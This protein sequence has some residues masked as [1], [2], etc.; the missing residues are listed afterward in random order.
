MV[1]VFDPSRRHPVATA[2][3]RSRRNTW[4][5]LS[6][7]L[8]LAMVAYA[9]SAWRSGT[10]QRNTEPAAE[11][12]VAG[13]TRQPPAPSAA[14]TPPHDQ[15]GGEVSDPPDEDRAEDVPEEPE[16][17]FAYRVISC[18]RNQY[19][20]ALAGVEIQVEPVLNLGDTPPFTVIT[21]PGGCAG[22]WILKG[23]YDFSATFGELTV[24]KRYRV[25]DADLQFVDLIFGGAEVA[26]GVI[27]NEAGRPVADAWVRLLDTSMKTDAGVRLLDMSMKTD[28]S[29]RYSLSS[30]NRP[31]QFTVEHPD[32]CTLSLYA[33]AASEI[34]EVIV[35]RSRPRLVIH[36]S[37]RDGAPL[38]TGATVTLET[39][40]RP[41]GELSGGFG[42]LGSWQQ[43][44][45]PAGVVHFGSVDVGDHVLHAE[46]GSEYVPT[47]IPF[48]M[49]CQDRV[50][51]V[52][53]MRAAPP[54]ALR[55]L[56]P[57]G[58][59]VQDAQI[60]TTAPDLAQ[61]EL[62]L[63]GVTDRLGVTTLADRIGGRIDRITLVALAPYLPP[64][65]W[66]IPLNLGDLTLR[67]PEPAHLHV[68]L[69]EEDRVEEG[70][71]EKNPW[72]AER[73]A[74]VVRAPDHAILDELLRPPVPIAKGQVELLLPGGAFRIVIVA[75]DI[76][77]A[78]TEVTLVAGEQRRLVIEPG[79]RV[80]VV[81]RVRENGEDAGGG[82]VT[83]TQGYRTAS[84]TVSP[85]GTFALSVYGA[86]PYHVRYQR[87]CC[88][89]EAALEPP[90]EAVAGETPWT[91][92][93]AIETHELRGQV[94]DIAGLPRAGLRG[95]LEIQGRVLCDL[96]T[97]REGRFRLASVAPGRYLM[98][99][100]GSFATFVEIADGPV[101]AY[102][103]YEVVDEDD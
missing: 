87:N 16:R 2:H 74:V 26:R 4:V 100:F 46:A 50:L 47:R 13:T 77:I 37:L 30:T 29:G 19:E 83:L 22:A 63:Q 33:S 6:C 101:E 72:G 24:K 21:D 27:Q 44:V 42:G 64:M 91:I 67:L 32:H 9:G 48:R 43:P 14:R 20:D 54:I 53:L 56:G 102:C 103:Y 88:C 94:V 45:G 51:E 61:P 81:G 92:E 31:I 70:R 57:N 78:E 59:P 40:A 18:A 76:A 52:S 65:V 49:D 39:P 23:L 28:Q 41:M 12:T 36:L 15:N 89:H 68:R 5:G 34:P 79:P 1:S 95:T 3:R 71:V 60:F 35:L 58:A 38:S 80:L 55:L 17:P 7:A 93:L 86:G 85:S 8:F 90:Q 75:G 62:V 99:G 11:A 25:T 10:P 96:V 84:A 98:V 82:M 97:D 73:R 66:K 69:V